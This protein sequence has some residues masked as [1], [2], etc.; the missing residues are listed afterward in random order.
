MLEAESQLFQ[1][2]ENNV[3]EEKKSPCPREGLSPPIQK[4]GKKRYKKPQARDK[5]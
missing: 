4:R 1:S 2:Q 3:E 5:V